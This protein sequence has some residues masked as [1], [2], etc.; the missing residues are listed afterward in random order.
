MPHNWNRYQRRKK[1]GYKFS[2]RDA[3][4]KIRRT[5]GWK[6]NEG[7]VGCKLSLPGCYVN[8]RVRV[9][10]VRPKKRKPKEKK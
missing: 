8:K 6:D 4:R 2:I 9:I 1:K 10:I 7:Y 3:E 5:Y